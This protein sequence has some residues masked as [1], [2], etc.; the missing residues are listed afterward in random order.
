[1]YTREQTK[2]IMIKDVQIGGNNDVVIQS[3]T[4]TKTH[5][6]KETL[7]QIDALKKEGCQIVRVAVLSQEDADSL[8]ELVKLSTL[9]IVADIHFN[10]K[11]ALI[12][13]DAGVGKIRINPGNI[14]D[15]ENTKKVVLKC[16]E[17]K[18]PIRI[19]V[20]SGS[21]PY[22]LVQ[23]YGWTAKC[24]IE[25]AKRHI[26]ILENLNF[27]NIILSL[28]ATDPL[29]AIEAYELAAKLWDYPLHLGITESGSYING[30]IKSAT[31][32][33]ILLNQKIGNTIRISLS[34]DPVKEIK[35]AKKI[36]NSLG[37]YKNMVDVIACPTCGRLEYEMNSI[38]EELEKYTE[39]MH[40]PYK[41]AILGCAVNGPGEAKEAD[42][43]ISGGK[44][45]GIIFKKG[46]LYKILPQ[47]ELV[48]ALKKII[49]N[50][51]K[52]FLKIQNKK[53]LE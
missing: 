28:K 9:P 14:G 32:L 30:A 44:E 35:T 33:G 16:Q 21:L 48:D 2:K 7:N 1:M 42:V 22:D 12:A 29:M 15:K 37:L 24:M 20:N 45:R 19:G 26:K 8:K 41:I 43:G 23:Q 18:I 36:L 25:S 34:T 52:Q 27:Y 5:N 4:T 17:K 10:Y 39:Q 40:F 38:V 53:Q 11:F 6:I 50:D 49:Q 13:A 3:M 51:Y 47:E 46:E 31:G